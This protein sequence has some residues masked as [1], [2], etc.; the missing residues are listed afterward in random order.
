M[1]NFTLP[2]SWLE[3]IIDNPQFIAKYKFGKNDFTRK[4]TWTFP[5]IFF[6]ISQMISSR[7]QSEINNYFS[8]LFK[9]E[10]PVRCHFSFFLKVPQQDQSKCIQISIGSVG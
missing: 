2:F 10:K 3:K 8:E 1:M 4:H 9:T 5:P 6:F 7:L